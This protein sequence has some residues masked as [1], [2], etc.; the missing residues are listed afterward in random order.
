MI[1]YSHSDVTDTPRIPPKNVVNTSCKSP[2]EVLV[3]V[4]KCEPGASG[5]ACRTSHSAVKSNRGLDRLTWVEEDCPLALSCCIRLD[6]GQPG[7]P[8]GGI[9]VVQRDFQKAARQ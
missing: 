1:G 6:E 5:S 4:E 9:L 8:Y 2:K 7:C 3:V